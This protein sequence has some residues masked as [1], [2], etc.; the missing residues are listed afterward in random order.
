MA[1][2]DSNIGLLFKIKADSSTAK[3]E[4]AG[5]KSW[6]LTEARA[7]E[8]SVNGMTGSLGRL[9]GAAGLGAV[10]LAAVGAGAAVYQLAKHAADF[11]DGLIDLNAKTNLSIETLSVLKANTAQTDASF[12]SISNSLVIFQKNIA[13]A[14]EGNSELSAR[15]RAMGVDLKGGVEPALK[16]TLAALNSYAD[17]A[18]KTK[19]ATDLFGRSGAEILVVL[20]QMGGDLDKATEAARRLGLVVSTEDAKAADDFNDQMKQL[21]QT[22]QGFTFALGKS[23]LPELNNM[24]KSVSDVVGWVNRLTAA[25]GGLKGIASGAIKLSFEVTGIP[26]ISRF[27]QGNKGSSASATD[28]WEA[29][30]KAAPTFGGSGGGGGG[31]GPKDISAIRQQL[32]L[33][34]VQERAIKRAHDEEVALARDAYDQKRITYQ[35]YVEIVLAAEEKMLEARLAVLQ[36]EEDEA[37]NSDLLPRQKSVKLAQI[38]EDELKS[39][40]DYNRKVSD[41][42]ADANI[43]EQKSI[44]DEL[45][46]NEERYQAA[47]ELNERLRGLWL[48]RRRIEAETLAQSAEELERRGGNPLVVIERRSRAEAQAEDIR[49]QQFI[50]GI[51]RERQDNAR[52]VQSYKD[53]L[54][55]EKGLNEIEEA[56]AARHAGEMRRLSAELNA[57]TQR[58]DPLSKR[59]LFG[60][61]FADLIEGG[62]GNLQALAQTSY[63]AFGRMS[64]AVGNFGTIASGAFQSFAQ[65]LAGVLEQMI[66]TGET[67]PAALRKLTAAVIAQIASQAAV[68]AIYELA[69][70]F[71]ALARMFFGDP[72]AGAEAAAH[73]QSA[74]IY[75]TVAGVAAVAGRAIAPAGGSTGTSGGGGGTSSSG[76]N[77]GPRIINQDTKPTPY[78]IVLRVDPSITVDHVA[79][80]FRNNGVIRQLV[81]GE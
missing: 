79:N 71:A 75:G 60:D 10:T 4:I 15:F 38:R 11:A 29:T 2:S 36:K 78:V 74:A 19:L 32:G 27:I 46:R 18:A 77:A 62:S 49:H 55:T 65:G 50:A 64:E 16:Q 33:L 17:G 24:A 44:Q 1:I 51:E 58:Q 40:S 52:R 41:L 73:F 39:I 56:E 67:G 80:D 42:K 53:F 70:G 57:A 76:Q 9:A 35:R 59:S 61:R 43:E 14:A 63:E 26:G 37:R 7:I 45:K 12:H 25:I 5:F 68:K 3:S 34:E 72:K 48:D 66:L 8:S 23:L 31:G 54:A 81:K 47:L 13:K 21:H 20:K 30:G 69:E 28:S 22:M 6:M